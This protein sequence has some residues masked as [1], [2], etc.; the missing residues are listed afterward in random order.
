MWEV[1]VLHDREWY[2]RWFF[3]FEVGFSVIRCWLSLLSSDALCFSGVRAVECLFLNHSFV[4][5]ISCRKTAWRSMLLFDC[6]WDQQHECIIMIFG[7]REVVNQIWILATYRVWA[8]LFHSYA[9]KV[10]VIVFCSFTGT[11]IR[12]SSLRG[13]S[14]NE[15]GNGNDQVKYSQH[16]FALQLGGKE[17]KWKDLV[18]CVGSLGSRLPSL[19]IWVPSLSETKATLWDEW[20]GKF[21]PRIVNDWMLIRLWTKCLSGFWNAISAITRICTKSWCS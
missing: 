14:M 21:S 3:Q 9:E 2:G 11:L 15:F 18:E 5:H 4:S 17:S 19:F 8:W 7:M 1:P 6:L 16:H 13:N 12:S 10:E 20:G